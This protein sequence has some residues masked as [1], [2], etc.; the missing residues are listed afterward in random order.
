MS[1]TSLTKGILTRVHVN[2]HVA[3]AN[4][5]NGTDHPAITIKSSKGNQYAS[6][7]TFQGVWT[8]VSSPL[9]PLS[10]GATMWI[11]GIDMGN[12]LHAE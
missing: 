6:K 11:E 2:Q 4:K 10:C 3:R 5:K 8:L 9:K 1:G 12:N 7:V